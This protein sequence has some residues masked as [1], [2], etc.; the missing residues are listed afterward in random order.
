MKLLQ[1][2]ASSMLRGFALAF[3]IVGVSSPLRAHNEPARVAA[4]RRPEILHNV[5]IEQRLGTE[6]GAGGIFRD[7]SGARVAL[8][9]YFVDKPSILVFSYFD[10][11]MLCPLVLDGLVRSVKPLSLEIGRDFEVIVISI[12]E[13]DDVDSARAKK[14]EYVSRYAREGSG[15]GWHFLTG[16]KRA[17]DSVTRQAGFKYAFDEASQQFVHASAIFV[18]TPAGKIARVLY[19]LDYSPK[20]VRLAL[21]EAANG[22][23]GTVIDQ[24][25]LYCYHYDPMTGKYGLVIMNSLRVA[26]SATVLALLSYIGLMLRRDR[27][28]PRTQAES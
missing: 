2:S 17:I 14:A 21:V 13:R 1:L 12:N 7:E 18:L 16:D 26:G 9:D 6:L 25:L 3:A 4:D 28:A 10:C 20:D 15:G 11:S 27:R 24:M 5:G 22:K 19:G 23:I 8:Q